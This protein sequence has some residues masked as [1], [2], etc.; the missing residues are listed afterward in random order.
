M[1]II[2]VEDKS[3]E[4]IEQQPSNV[5]QCIIVV[6]KLNIKN[7]PTKHVYAATVFA[8]NFSKLMREREIYIVDLTRIL[9]QYDQPLHLHVMNDE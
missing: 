3:Q 6:V 4:T 7:C 8:T 5:K 9:L 1:R 2:F